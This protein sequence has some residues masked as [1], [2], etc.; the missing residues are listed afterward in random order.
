MA[1][2][3]RAQEAAES[4]KESA[5]RYFLSRLEVSPDERARSKEV[6]EDLIFELGP[7][8]DRYPTWHPIVSDYPRIPGREY[9]DGANR[10]RFPGI[11]HTVWMAHGFITCPYGD[12][13]EVI[14]G[15]NKLCPSH[16]A[17]LTAERLDVKLYNADA[18]PILVRCNW[19]RSLLEDG[20]IPLSIAA[21]LLL[22]HE[23]PIWTRSEVA[24]TWETMR[25]NF[26]G[27][28]H[29]S[30]SSLF[31][32]QETGQGLKKLWNTVIYTGMYGPIMV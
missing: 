11:D 3:F 16:I 25:G 10:M 2:S 1:L 26:L 8:I 7:V 21:A 29:G 5:L 12:G 22:S 30:R 27:V 14:D 28:P 4:N 15:V 31:V 6:L 23:V 13:Q 24:E 17:H 18:Q 32:N 19:E 20:T 9:E